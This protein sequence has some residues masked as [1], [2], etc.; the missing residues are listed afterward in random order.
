[1]VS[2]LLNGLSRRM[3]RWWWCSPSP[4]STFSTTASLTNWSGTHSV[5]PVRYY[6]PQTVAE[7]EALVKDAH[8][9]G[10]K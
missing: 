2:R 9:R 3:C 10:I 7:L 4:T 1:M 8:E 6:E 5:E